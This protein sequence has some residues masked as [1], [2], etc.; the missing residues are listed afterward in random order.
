M[1]NITIGWSNTVP[2][3]NDLVGLG[4]DAIRSLKSNVQGALD[5]E[6]FFPSAGGAAG[7]HRAGSA[8]VF[9]G[10]ASQVSSADTSGRLMWNST[11]STLHYVGSEGTGVIGGVRDLSVT[12]NLPPLSAS[13]RF[14]ISVVSF[15]QNTWPSGPVSTGMPAASSALRPF[16]FAS[17]VT[18]AS[19]ILTPVFPMV[20]GATANAP[21]VG[22]YK[23]D[24][25][26]STET[27]TV[28]LLCVGFGPA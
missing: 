10:T 4:D 19:S 18:T 17:V 14:V 6:H 12:T 25:S 24:G 5:A 28:N 8:R 11:D 15:T 7:A 1:S 3:A 21:Q 22:L 26:A 9:V 16:Y 2:A 13:S 27:W 23:A 20:F